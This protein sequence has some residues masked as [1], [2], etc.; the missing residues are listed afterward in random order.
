MKLDIRQFRGDT[1][2]VVRRLDPSA[3]ALQDEEFRLAA[4]VEF[5]AD[6]RKDVAKVRLVGRVK[7]TLECS[8]SRCLEPFTVP[9]DAPFDLLFLPAAENAG[10]GEKEI[11][12]DDIGVSYYRD[13]VI[14]LGEVMREQFILALPM[15]PLCREDC[16]GLCPVCGINRNREQ[17]DCQ[18]GWVDPRMAPLKNLLEG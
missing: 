17:C 13:D 3:F 5:E 18:T 8:C 14:D 6:V 7:A 11:A 4:P 16:Q 9:V 1:E 12:E 15:K 10:E 2:H